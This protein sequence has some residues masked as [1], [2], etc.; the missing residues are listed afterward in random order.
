MCTVTY[1][2]KNNTDFIFTSSRDVPYKRAK[3]LPPQ[4]YTIENVVLHYPKDP[5]GQGSWIGT[6]SNKRLVCLLNGGFQ[7]HKST[8]NYTKSRGLIVKEL[9]LVKDNIHNY[10]K[11][12][13]LE[14]IEPFTIIIVDWHKSKLQLLE[15]VWTG[16]TRFISQLDSQKSHIWSS[17][18]LYDNTMKQ[19]REEWF[20]QWQKTNKPIL[21]FH[22]NAGIGDAKVD[23]LMDRGKIGTVS[24][25][26]IIKQR[27]AISFSYE[28]VR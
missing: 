18:T 1:L 4:D 25:S 21:D 3:A 20:N 17:A 8:G 14:N 6:S 28:D 23:V 5:Q 26:Q 22:H 10:I 16:D 2:V 19:L 27:D 13:V 7:N 24:I 15:L 12:I 9:L 11:T